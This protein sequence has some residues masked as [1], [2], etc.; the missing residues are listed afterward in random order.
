MVDEAKVFERQEM[1]ALHQY[2]FF[3]M[4]ALTLLLYEVKLHAAHL[5]T[6]ATVGTAAKEELTGITAPAEAYTQSAVYETLKLHV[7]ACL[8]DA[9]YLVDCEFARQHHLPEAHIVELLHV[10]RSLIVHL[11]A[12]MER[13]G[14]QVERKQTQILHY[15]CIDINVVELANE[16]LHIVQLII[17]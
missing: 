14:G 10:F 8:M 4:V 17:A 12:C 16:L 13:N 11:G 1:F 15:E 2:T 6:L 5:G 3:D 9:S 7:G